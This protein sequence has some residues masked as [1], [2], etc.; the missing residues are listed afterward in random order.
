[1]TDLEDVQRVNILIANDE[2]NNFVSL[3]NSFVMRTNVNLLFY[4]KKR[5][6]Y[7]NGPIAIYLRFTVDGQRMHFKQRPMYLSYQD[8]KVL[9]AFN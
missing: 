1:V 4:L 5:P 7:K 2:I 9:P 8:Q 3:F 6:T